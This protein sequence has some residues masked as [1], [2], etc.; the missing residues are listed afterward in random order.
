MEL[1]TISG[2][3][4]DTSVY[5]P[6][7]TTNAELNDGH[8]SKYVYSPSRVVVLICTLGT[9]GNVLVIAVYFWNLPTSTSVY[10]F[11]LAVVDSA[12]RVS[13]IILTGAPVSQLTVTLLLASDGM[14]TF[15]SVLLLVFLSTDRLM[16]VAWPHTFCLSASRAKMVVIAIPAASRCTAVQKVNVLELVASKISSHL[17]VTLQWRTTTHCVVACVWGTDLRRM[18]RACL[19]LYSVVLS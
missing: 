8:P 5:Q 3:S 19:A 4:N 11:A 2:W 7:V 13:G 12:A 10:V 1:T 14:S 15:L 16:T 17:M 9:P 18:C 6:S